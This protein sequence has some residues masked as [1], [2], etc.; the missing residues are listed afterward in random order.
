MEADSR[1]EADRSRC[2]QN[3][4]EDRHQQRSE[5]AGA[6][7]ARSR[8]YVAGAEPLVVHIRLHRRTL[9]HGH[10]RADLGEAFDVDLLAAREMPGFDLQSQP[11]TVGNVAG[12]HGRQWRVLDDVLE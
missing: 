12:A 8:V 9:D 5:E 4:R 11:Q 2:E 3:E 6:D 1:E 10:V 7:A